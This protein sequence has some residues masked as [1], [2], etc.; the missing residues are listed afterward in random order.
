MKLQWWSVILKIKPQ[1]FK[2]TKCTFGRYVQNQIFTQLHG[3]S[4]SFLPALSIEATAASTAVLCVLD[5][6]QWTSCGCGAAVSSAPIRAQ[7]WPTQHPAQYWAV[8]MWAADECKQKRE[9]RMFGRARG[10]LTGTWW[11]AEIVQDSEH[12]PKSWFYS[13]TFSLN[14]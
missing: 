1:H 11:S 10:R 13:T 3:T 7:H 6:L 14:W 9:Q 5:G 8:A 4:R 12:K 2:R